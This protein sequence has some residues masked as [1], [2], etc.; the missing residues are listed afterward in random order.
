MKHQECKLPHFSLMAL[1]LLGGLLAACATPTRSPISV[2]PTPTPLPRTF[3]GDLAYRWVER[4]T[5]LGPRLIGS[6][7]NRQ[8]GDQILVELTTLGWEIQEQT[9]TYQN[10]P[11]RNLIAYQKGDGPAVLLGAHYDSRKSADRED[12]TRPVPGA[13]DGASGVAVLLE[14]ARAL[15]EPLPYTVYLAFFDA[16]DNGNL[17]GW[18]FSV[19]ASYMAET[20]GQAEWQVPLTA[21]VVVD[22]IGDADQQLYYETNSDPTL[23]E[24]L[25]AIAG[26]LGYGD[27][28]VPQPRHTIIDD[29]LPFL[30]RGIPAVDIIDFDYPYWHTTQDTADKVSAASLETVGRT[31]E[32]WLEGQPYG[33]FP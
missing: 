17:D 10:M 6:E 25:W 1:L 7:A 8:A 14:L 30:Q 9:F 26:Q 33:E 18:P 2:P 22:M 13:N 19:G 27:R 29:H 24:Q 21:V 28:F 12:P 23:R 5:A 16:E 32:S 20:W 15:D 31:L 4:Q 3:T 11:I